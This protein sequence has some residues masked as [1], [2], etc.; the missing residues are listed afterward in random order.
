[1][2]DKS[3]RL[4][5]FVDAGSVFGMGMTAADGLRYSTGLAVTWISPMGP[6]KISVAAPLNKQPDDRLQ[7]FQFT[8]GS[9][10]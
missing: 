3:V 4:S 10:F 8:F 7:M 5:T 2:N 9:L 6:L 1:M